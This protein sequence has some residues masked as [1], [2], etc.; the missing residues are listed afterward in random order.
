M[1]RRPA[2][3]SAFAWVMTGR[4]IGVFL[5][6]ILLAWAIGRAGGWD[7]AVPIFGAIT[8]LSAVAAIGLAVAMR[9]RATTAQGTSR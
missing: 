6:P 5:G 3:P 8:T 9:E 1:L 4:N 7:I 2:G